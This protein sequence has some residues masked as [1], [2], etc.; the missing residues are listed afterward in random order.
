MELADALAVTLAVAGVLEELK[1]PY[2]LGGSLAS[3]LHGIPRSTQDA[4][5]VADL[6]AEHVLPLVAALRP[7]FYVD[8]ERVA[9]AVRRRGSFNAIH[10][11]T[12][13]KVDIF[14]L[15]DDPLS[16]L[17]M[18]RCQ[19]IQLPGA[20]EIQLPVAT[21]EDIILQKLA[22][23]RLG[24]EVSERQWDD[25]LGVLKVRKGTLDLPYL[26]RWAAELEVG[27][28]LRRAL[29]ESGN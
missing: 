20:E 15:K 9:D 1:V 5:L 7:S 19:W 28:L 3:S 6:Q 24:G 22:W 25:L 8:E 13:T 12:M 23:F 17:E 11:P 21:A 10:L 18:E 2:L 16:R 4:D 29:A 14:V 27:D 26:E